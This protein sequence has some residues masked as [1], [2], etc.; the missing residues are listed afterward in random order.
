M[1]TDKIPQPY[2]LDGVLTQAGLTPNSGV[3][4]L[5]GGYAKV[6]ALVVVYLRLS[7]TAQI[8]TS[9]AFISGF[10]T[11]RASGINAGESIVAVASGLKGTGVTMLQRGAIFNGNTTTSAVIPANTTLVLSCVYFT[12]D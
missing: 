8:S 10:P 3:T 2:A 6:G 11:V 12:D 7:V 9:T 4:I 1:A 5:G